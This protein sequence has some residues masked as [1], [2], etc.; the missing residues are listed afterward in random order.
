MQYIFHVSLGMTEYILESLSSP[1]S[2]LIPPPP[3]PP[4]TFLSPSLF[5]NPDLLNFG[6]AR[7]SEVDGCYSKLHLS[8]LTPLLMNAAYVVFPWG[9][10]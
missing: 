1:Q 2:Q 9:D 8:V 5:S 10:V 7:N 6:R 4:L 3:P